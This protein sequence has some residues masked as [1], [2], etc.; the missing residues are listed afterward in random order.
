MFVTF[1]ENN[2]NWDRIYLKCNSMP[3]KES[4]GF[5]EMDDFK[6]VTIDEAK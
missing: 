3:P 4:G 5:P 1:E 2:A 6:W